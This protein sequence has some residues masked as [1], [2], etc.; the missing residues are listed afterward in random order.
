VASVEIRA[1][2]ETAAAAQAAASDGAAA[3]QPS[4]APTPVEIAEASEPAPKV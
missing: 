1:E 3:D 2:T 4:L